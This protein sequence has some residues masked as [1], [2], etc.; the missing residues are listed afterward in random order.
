MTALVLGHKNPDTDS[1]VSALSAAN[2]YRGR[3]IDVKTGA[4]GKPAP[5]TAFVLERFGLTA[6]EV[7]TSVAGEEVYLVDYS[8]LAQAPDDFAKCK[9]LGII[10][11]HKL[12]DVTSD[13]PVEVFI[14][15]VGCSN[16]VIKELHDIYG[17]SIDPKLAGAMM[18]A[19]LSDTVLFKSPTCTEADK[20][21]VAD[22]AKIAGV[23]NPLDI[24]ME[25]FKAKSNL[26]GASARDLIFRDFKDFDMSG[27]KV[28]IGQLEL[29]SLSLITPELK[30]Q[31]QDELNKVKAEGRHSAVL[32]IT[33]I[34][35][36]GSELMMCSDNG[37]LIA[38]ALNTQVSDEMWMPGVMSRKKQVVPNL[39][40]A[41]KA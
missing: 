9:L 38:K 24:G 16:T 23:D 11:H 37:E 19:I 1:I 2:L 31:L 7:V 40:Q 10:D 14:K 28:G 4:Q 21:A 29:V 18:C 22:L 25:M 36:E 33:D 8:D 15:P 41:F 39:E 6:P 32:V 17:V 34:M 20:K 30:A 26:A 12:G 27:N 5:E 3:G 35:K 13:S